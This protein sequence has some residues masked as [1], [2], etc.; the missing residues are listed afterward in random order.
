MNLHRVTHFS[1]QGGV[2]LNYVKSFSVQFMNESGYW[3][4]YVED[5]QLKVCIYPVNAVVDDIVY[6]CFFRILRFPFTET[7]DGVSLEHS[8]AMN[9]WATRRCNTAP[10]L[11][12]VYLLRTARSVFLLA[13]KWTGRDYGKDVRNAVCVERNVLTYCSFPIL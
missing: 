1:S 4:D 11:Y 2:D 5:G 3:K 12:A 8:V 6:L 9:S 13:R 10:Y 7:V